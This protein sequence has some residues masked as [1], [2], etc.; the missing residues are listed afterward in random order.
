MLHRHEHIL[1]AHGSAVPSAQSSAAGEVNFASSVH[2]RQVHLVVE[3]CS[4]RFVRVVRSTGDGK[5]VDTSVKVGVGRADNGT[6]PAGESLVVGV[7]EAVG[8]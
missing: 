2:A 8:D 3:L 6:V 7:V 4:G 1:D 5:E